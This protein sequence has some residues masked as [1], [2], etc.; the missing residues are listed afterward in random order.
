MAKIGSIIDGKYEILK[1]IGHGGMSTVYLAMDTRLNKQWAIKEAKKTANDENNQVVMQSLSSEADLMKKL[2][3]PSFP[4]IVDIIENEDTICIVEDYV[5]G[6]SLDKIIERYGAQKEDDVIDWSIQLCDALEY[7]HT[8]KHPIVYRDMKPA[9][10]RL[11]P[12]PKNAIKILDFGIAKELVDEDH[13]ATKAIG[14]RGYASPEQSIAGH[15][16]DGRS[17][18]YSLGVTMH[19]LLTAQD[20]RKILEFKPIREY[21]HTVTDKTE[22]L[23]YIIQKCMRINPADR[24]QTCGELKYDLQHVTQLTRRYHTE[25]KRKILIFSTLVCM[26]LLFGIM[27][28]TMYQLGG[29]SVDEKINEYTK[30][31]QAADIKDD[32]LNEIFTEAENDLHNQVYQFDFIHE[33][34]TKIQEKNQIT[35]QDLNTLNTIIEN[36]SENSFKNSLSTNEDKEKYAQDMMRLAKYLFFEWD[37]SPATYSSYALKAIQLSKDCV[38]KDLSGDVA[39]ADE[40]DC[41]NSLISAY[42]SWSST[43][44]KDGLDDTDGYQKTFDSC[45]KIFEETNGNISDDTR[46]WTYTFFDTFTT[47][48]IS[49]NPACLVTNRNYRNTISADELI[50]AYKTIRSG[51]N[52]FKQQEKAAELRRRFKDSSQTLAGKKCYNDERIEQVWR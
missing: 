47:V 9:N 41:L 49:D 39:F 35:E 38:D 42:D 52:E 40:V 29:Q 2:N 16:L 4:R 19:H 23:E 34:I 27:S 32:D 10:I 15:K 11:Q 46:Y 14:T 25:Q 43:G 24:Y 1:E 36:C 20:P 6:E 13:G 45:L 12:E 7:L 26:A 28:F 37:D 31:I 22:G 50:N 3:Y 18:I 17:D 51:L 48:D 5:E 21:T 8:R 30:E 33:Y 44:N